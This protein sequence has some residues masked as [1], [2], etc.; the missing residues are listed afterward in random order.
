MKP[1]AGERDTS[2]GCTGRKVP[3]NMSVQLPIA[4]RGWEEAVDFVFQLNADYLYRTDST[5]IT[6]ITATEELTTRAMLE[7][8]RNS[9]EFVRLYSASVFPSLLTISEAI[10]DS[11]L[12]L[13]LTTIG[14]IILPR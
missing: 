8:S 4:I 5:R 7:R 11:A 9:D 1:T 13:P 2:E 14:S 6:R 3:E 12:I 10:R